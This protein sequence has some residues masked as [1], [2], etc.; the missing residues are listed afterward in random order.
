[1]WCFEI[2]LLSLLTLRH[3]VEELP[4]LLASLNYT[5]TLPPHSTTTLL[6]SVCVYSEETPYITSKLPYTSYTPLR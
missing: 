5:H 3:K 6:L 2:S 4:L 1:M